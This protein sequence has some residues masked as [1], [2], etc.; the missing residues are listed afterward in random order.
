MSDEPRSP[1]LVLL[2]ELPTASRDAPTPTPD[3]NAIHGRF[4][5]GT[6]FG[7]RYRIIELLGRG[8]MG[9]VY[10]ADDLELGQAVA[11]KFLPASVAQDEIALARLRSEVRLARQISHPNVC[12][13]FDIGHLD[14]QYFLS[15]EYVDGEDLASVLRRMGR[16]SREKALQ[17]ARQI[18]AG[19]RAAHENGV[20]HRD[21]KP[22]NIMIDGRGWVR[23]MDFG[24]SGLALELAGVKDFAGTPMYMAPEQLEGS[25]TSVRT[26]LFSLGVVL[27]EV[28]TGRHPFSANTLTQ[29]RE[30]YRKAQSPPPPSEYAGELEPNVDSVILRCLDTD[31]KARPASALE[32]AAALGGGDS[33]QAV[34]AAGETPSP[35][36][37][38]AAG[39]AGTL[40]LRTAWSLLLSIGLVLCGCIALARYS[41]VLG[42]AGWEKNPEVLIDRAREII[43]ATGHPQPLD[44]YAYGIYSN[45][46]L[47]G[48]LSEQKD[49]RTLRRNLAAMEPTP[50]RFWYRQSPEPLVPRTWEMQVSR[51]DPQQDVPGMTY[52]LLD[53][54]GILRT[55]EVVPPRSETETQSW[56]RP[57]PQ[58][59]WTPLFAAAGLDQ[60]QFVAADPLWIPQKPF[61]VRAS[62]NGTHAGLPAHIDAAAF[63]GMVVSF[64]IGEPWSNPQPEKPSHWIDRIPDNIYATLG[65]L[66]FAAG[67]VLARRNLRRGRGD[68]RGGLRLAVYMFV[69]C[70][71]SWALKGHLQASVLDLWR[72][73]IF[74]VADSLF[75]ATFVWIAY[76]A[77][78]PY[79][80][81]YWPDLL[82]SWNR[83]VAG[84]WRDPLVGRDVLIGTL[85]GCVW[86]A[87]INLVYALPLWIRIPRV[88]PIHIESLPLGTSAQALGY[89]LGDQSNAIVSSLAVTLVLVSARLLF[90]RKAPAVAFTCL[91]VATLIVGGEN[92]FVTIPLALLNALLL[93]TALVRFSILTYGTCILVGTVTIHFPMTLDFSRWY[94]GR[95]VFALCVVLAMALYG[96]RCALGKQAAFGGL[97]AED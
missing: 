51:D 53:S 10:R 60:R 32:V 62:W 97:I 27:Y 18:C 37:L 52:V 24:L 91:V 75:A 1:A 76:M 84:R 64:D 65:F 28:L 80:R 89:L 69:L 19:L 7:E 66:L 68:R 61:D 25:G 96:F 47:I 83:L 5:P 92:Y 4:I 40:P 26:D 57:S 88:T 82:I 6:V 17:I 93:T 12:R 74:T 77:L 43:R 48:Y 3:Y 16:P 55:Y 67:L 79:A 35:E 14:G 2:D 59:D 20:L 22:A 29:L 46:G 41:T 87:C 71:L 38:A 30:D 63:H 13:V 85:F 23:L 50:I 95:S 11:L 86:A 54:R 49:P 78:D 58:P 9:E 42:L 15:M 73:F 56:P 72:A 8:G 36:L 21:L 81:K 34:L 39:G 45:N 33:L 94:A 31:P 44:D 90:R 70:A